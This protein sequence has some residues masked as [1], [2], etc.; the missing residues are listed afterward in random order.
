MTHQIRDAE[1]HEMEQEDNYLVTRPTC[2]GNVGSTNFDSMTS[3]F[4]DINQTEYYTGMDE[5]SVL[6]CSNI[7]KELSIL[8]KK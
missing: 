4:E 3:Y 5:F 7:S 6:V 2:I 1:L 8:K